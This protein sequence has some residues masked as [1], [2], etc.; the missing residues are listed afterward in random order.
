MN[1]G[2][3]LSPGTVLAGRY[4][5]LGEIGR[6][7][8]SI[9]FEARDTQR[10]RRV[11]VKLLSP[12]AAIAHLTREQLRRYSE[13]LASVEHPGIVKPIE[14][15]EAGLETLIVMERVEGSDLGS[16]VAAQG[17]LSPHDVAEIGR[18]VA[19]ALAAA[20]ARGLLHRGVKPQNV[21][22]PEAGAALLTDFGCSN[23]EGQEAPL[24]DQRPASSIG[25]LSPELLEGSYTDARS[26]IYALGMTLY[27]ALVG[28]LPE[29]L[30]DADRPGHLCEGF[31]P[32][33]VRPDV[34]PWLDQ[35]IARA[36]CAEPSC[37]IETA[38]RLAR[39]LD[40]QGL[41]AGVGTSR[42]AY[43]ADC[44]ILCR[45][46]GTLGRAICPHCEDAQVK[47]ANTLVKLVAPNG[48]TADDEE[49]VRK[50]RGLTGSPSDERAVRR[51]ARGKQ[52]LVKL[53]RSQAQRVSQRL[54]AYGF[55]T[56]LVPVDS[57][58]A[59]LPD[60][61]VTLALIPIGLGFAL[62]LRGDAVLFG[63]GLAG[64]L[65]LLPL[66]HSLMQH[67]PLIPDPSGS[68]PAPSLAQ[69]VAEVMP[70][71]QGGEARKLLAEI[72]RLSRD[73]SLRLESCSDGAETRE[74]LVALAL[75]ACDAAREL[76]A[77][78][79][80]LDALMLHGEHRFEPPPGLLESR[81]RLGT[82]RS[83]LAQYLLEA[84][85]T[86]SAIRGLEI[87]DIPEI[88]GELEAIQARLI[89]ELESQQVAVKQAFSLFPLRS[90]PEEEG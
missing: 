31:H 28:E 68:R 16:R 42:E 75:S 41:P 29:E 11:V 24:E 74:T 60:W 36:T 14:L 37:R 35:I 30:Q 49:R 66:G 58:W 47:H 23:L 13:A 90:T 88:R 59:E 50:L 33:R 83:C 25:F 3:G 40:E 15:I 27:Y 51:V 44:C 39:G 82:A 26:D 6:G 72:L 22:L 76:A 86:L 78:D 20:H 1:A 55:E 4:E 45:E 19:D 65:V 62:A 2:T 7:E 61:L 43:L 73:I 69:K 80:I 38:E 67:P 70:E 9:V 34:P 48:Q 54:S 17:P 8:R 12:L 21:L 57:P 79:P 64:G 63:A 81:A 71:I 87:L 5:I 52:P 18:C 84:T 46:P 85:A 77:L 89:E 10:D 56:R 53:S 32:A